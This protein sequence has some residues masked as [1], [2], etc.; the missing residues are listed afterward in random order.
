MA[1]CAGERKN[2]SDKKGQ[3]MKEEKGGGHKNKNIFFFFKFQMSMKYNKNG[4][5]N[6]S[7]M[8]NILFIYINI[9]KK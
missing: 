8:R 9:E 5:N 6:W 3:E 2:T 7:A 4:T 1:T